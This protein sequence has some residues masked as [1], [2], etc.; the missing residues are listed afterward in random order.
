MLE[1]LRQLVEETLA[2][3]RLPRAMSLY[4]FVLAMVLAA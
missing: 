2:V 3:K 4:L 1:R